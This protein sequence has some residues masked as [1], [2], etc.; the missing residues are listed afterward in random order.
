MRTLST[1]IAE[2][3]DMLNALPRLTPCDGN[4]TSNFGMRIHP[5]SGE[6]K[7]HTG[8]D[9]AAP[10]GQPIRAAGDAVV[11]FSG[12]RN[13]Y[14]NMVELDH[15]FGYHT[16]YGHASRLLVKNGDTVRRGQV[17]A[18]VGATG[19]ATGPHLH[20][21]VIVDDTKVNPVPFLL[22]DPIAE[23]RPA[24]KAAAKATKAAAKNGTVGKPAPTRGTIAGKKSSA[25][26]GGKKRC[27]GGKSCKPGR[28]AKRGHR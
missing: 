1:V 6:E 24:P 12:T 4:L 3:R 27:C 19:A 16:L 11:K 7:M 20:Y 5:I 23:P 2:R 8:M 28:A 13:G 18:L 22:Q 25:K 9:I 10:S 26:D 17:I 15:G 14:G 21:E